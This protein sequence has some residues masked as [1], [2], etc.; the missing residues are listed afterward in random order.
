MDNKEFAKLLERRTRDFGVRII[1]LSVNY[2]QSLTL[3][4]L[5]TRNFSHFLFW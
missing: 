1:R 3:G 5:V 4:T 2:W